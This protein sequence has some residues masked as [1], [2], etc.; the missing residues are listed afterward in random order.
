MKRILSVLLIIATLSGCIL[1]FIAC[2]DNSSGTVVTGGS[3]AGDEWIDNLPDDLDFSG[4]A[5]N[6]VTMV[7]SGEG[8][9]SQNVR[10][11]IV[12]EESADTVDKQLFIRN[13]KVMQRLGVVIEGL[14]ASETRNLIDSNVMITLTSG[15]DDYDII[16]GNALNDIYISTHDVLL[17]INTLDQY[18]AAYIDLS[19]PYWPGDYLKEVNYKDK[20]WWLT[21]DITTSYLAQMQVIFVN[22]TLYEKYLFQTYGSLYDIVKNGDWTLDMMIEM[23]DAIFMDSGTKTDEND[24]GDINGILLE[25]ACADIYALASGVRFSTR[26]ADGVSTISIMN[27]NTVSF[28]EKYFEMRESKGSYYVGPDIFLDSVFVSGNGLFIRRGLAAAESTYREVENFYVV[29]VPKLEKSAEYR[30]RVGDWAS[31]LAIPKAC[32]N[33]AMAAATMEALASASYSLVTP[34]YYDEALKYKYTRDDNAAEM[35]DIIRA[36]TDVDFALMYGNEIGNLGYFFRNQTQPL[37]ASALQANQ[38]LWQKMLEK[39]TKKFDEM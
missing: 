10:S 17:D 11:I 33:Y 4:L 18:D 28:L 7:V 20:V 3:S 25:H 37:P 14:H 39:L 6:T 38:R 36:S 34:V 24:E 23:S 26:D 35:I 32:N 1:S 31:L 27:N 22:G 13:Q 5:D 16:V 12:D 15:S 21:G 29:P 30:T 2:A 9:R 19:Q 8:V